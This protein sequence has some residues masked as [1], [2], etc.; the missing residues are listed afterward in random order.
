MKSLTR[1][2]PLREEASI[3][4]FRDS[5]YSMFEEVLLGCCFNYSALELLA[6]SMCGTGVRICCHGEALPKFS[7]VFCA[8]HL[9]PPFFFRALYR[10]DE[11][12]VLS[13]KGSRE[14]K[15]GPLTRLNGCATGSS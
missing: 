4:N 1:D 9:P 2:C 14:F 6:Y 3:S 12:L 15:L 7:A 10:V 5:A 13:Y 8:V 11:D